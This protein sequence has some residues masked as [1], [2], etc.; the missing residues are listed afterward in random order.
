M[1]I[2][3]PKD[4]VHCVSYF[5]IVCCSN[6]LVS[7]QKELRS[8][9]GVYSATRVVEMLEVLRGDCKLNFFLT[10]QKNNI[11]CE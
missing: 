7:A 3:N 6:E 4:K 11:D 10:I 1:F 2:R 9:E 8:L 5:A